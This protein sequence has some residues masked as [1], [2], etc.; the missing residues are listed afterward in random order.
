MVK[1]IQTDRGS[2]FHILTYVFAKE[3]LIHRLTYSHTS[4]QNGVVESRHKRVVKKGIALL[5]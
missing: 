1:S 5:L 2:A 4:E 3:I